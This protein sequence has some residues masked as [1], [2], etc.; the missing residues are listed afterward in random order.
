MDL[1]E[2]SA[3]LFKIDGVTRRIHKGENIGSSGWTLV[4]ISNNE[5]VVRRNGEVRSIQTG[6][7]I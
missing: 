5:I 1:G 7:K 4:D 3:A 2:K 6:Q